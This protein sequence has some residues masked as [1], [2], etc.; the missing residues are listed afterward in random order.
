MISL[1]QGV[2]EDRLPEHRGPADAGSFGS[3]EFERGA[4][5]FCICPLGLIGT[6][7]LFALRAETRALKLL[8]V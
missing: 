2:L 3:S 8:V 6:S 7:R 1:A 5:R 4:D